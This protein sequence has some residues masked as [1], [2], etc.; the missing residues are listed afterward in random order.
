MQGLKAG[1]PKAGPTHISIEHSPMIKRSNPFQSAD[2]LPAEG[3][4]RNSGQLRMKNQLRITPAV[5]W[6][7]DG[8][9]MAGITNYEFA[10]RRRP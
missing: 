4:A 2:G 6:P 5:G 3:G 10:S 1:R 8:R 9:P 7:A